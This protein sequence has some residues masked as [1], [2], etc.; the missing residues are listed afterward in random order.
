MRR[1]ADSRGDARC[2]RGFRTKYLGV[3]AGFG[4]TAFAKSRRK[5]AQESRRPTQV[6]ISSRRDTEPV[7]QRHV[8]VSRRIVVGAELIIRFGLAVDDVAVAG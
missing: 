3:N 1:R 2:D 5:A 7:E 4:D 6:E 8:Q